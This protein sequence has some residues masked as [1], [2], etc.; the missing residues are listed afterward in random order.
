MTGR[1]LKGNVRLKK[2]ETKKT[3]RAQAGDIFEMRGYLASC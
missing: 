3:I 2:T 1:M